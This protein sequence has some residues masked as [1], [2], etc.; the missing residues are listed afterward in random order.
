M[1]DDGAGLLC[2]GHGH[3]G[4]DLGTC[5]GHLLLLR[6]LGLQ[7]PALLKLVHRVI[8]GVVGQGFLSWMMSSLVVDVHL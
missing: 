4:R 2:Y 5:P 1:N 3:L 7:H 8:C 6:Q